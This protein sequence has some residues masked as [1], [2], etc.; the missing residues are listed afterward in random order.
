MTAARLR[1]APWPPRSA[2]LRCH[3]LLEP[4]RS[5]VAPCRRAADARA[6]HQA[7]S[8]QD[9]CGGGRRHERSHAPRALR[10]GASRHARADG[11]SRGAARLARAD[12]VGP[13]C[14]TGD[15]FVQDWPL[16]EVAAGDLLVLWGAGAYGFVQ[17]SNYNAPPAPRRSPGGRQTLPRHSPPRIA[18]RPGARR[19]DATG[20]SAHR[21]PH[22]SL[23]R[24]T[25][26]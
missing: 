1:L 9:L 16:G 6:L 18:E 10:R 11:A 21:S 12:V 26:K 24:S 19:I 4:G 23:S 22:F 14:E 8:R 7:Q 13:V 17:A 3:L 15:C 20:G 2:R 25:L 5:I